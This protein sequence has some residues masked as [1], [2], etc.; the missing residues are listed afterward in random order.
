MVKKAASWAILYRPEEPLLDGKQFL[1]QGLTGKNV[2]D[3]LKNAYEAQI[4]NNISSATI[5][6]EMLKK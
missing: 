1:E 5:L 6:K 2:G 3:A 4:R